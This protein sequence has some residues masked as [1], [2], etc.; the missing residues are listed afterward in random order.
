MTYIVL[1]LIV[2]ALAAVVALVAGRGRTHFWPAVGLAAVVL[3]L[4]TAVFD[5]IMIAVDLF[6]YGSEHLSGVTVGLAP[7]EDFAW[8]LVAVLLLPAI[9]EFTDRKPR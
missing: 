5:N 7:I 9:W 1:S 6:R 4:L 8:P 2:I 3:I